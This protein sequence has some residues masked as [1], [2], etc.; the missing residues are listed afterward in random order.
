MG[1][2]AAIL[3]GAPLN[4]LDLNVVYRGDP[5]NLEHA[6][7]FLEE[8]HAVYRFPAERRLRPNLSHLGGR[9]HLN[10]T[11]RFGPLDFLATAGEGLDYEALLP[12]SPLV[13]LGGFSV[14]VLNLETIIAIKEQLRAP[15]DLAALPTLYAALREKQKRAQS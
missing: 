10:L 13:D 11:S 3:N 12:S 9:G 5:E 15:K 14:R 1:G 7:Q 2:L 4:T 8:A 6:L